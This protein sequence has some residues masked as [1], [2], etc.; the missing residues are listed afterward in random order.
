MPLSDIK[1]KLNAIFD[2][3]PDGLI[4]I[5]EAGAIQLFSSG[6]ERLFGYR[7]DEV[8]GANVKIFDAPSVSGGAR[9]LP[10]SVSRHW[11]QEDHRHWAGSFR[12]AQGQFGFPDVSVGWRDMAGGR[13]FLCGRRSRSDQA[14]AR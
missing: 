5:D 13:P 3:M 7:Q 14:E 4:V 2:T 1:A 6:A 10:C 12:S 9:W 8:L 11:R